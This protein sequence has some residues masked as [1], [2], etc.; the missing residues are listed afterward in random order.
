MS[1]FVDH[2][3][4]GGWGMFPTLV[5][6]LLLLGVGVRYAVTPEKRFV[7]LLAGLGVLTLSS[8]ALGFVTGLIATCCAIETERLGAGQDARITIVGFGESLNNVAFALVFVALAAVCTSYSAW[9]IS[10]IRTGAAEVSG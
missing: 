9:R 7:P 6:G 8:G 4:E 2:F 5:F 3:H 1:S 10:Q